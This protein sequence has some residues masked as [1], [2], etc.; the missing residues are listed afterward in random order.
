MPF[1]PCRGGG[2][3][4]PPYFCVQKKSNESTVSFRSED[5]KK[6]ETYELGGSGSTGTITCRIVGYNPTSSSSKELLRKSVQAN[7]VSKDNPW[8]IEAPESAKDWPYTQFNFSADT[9]YLTAHYK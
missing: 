5:I 8:V 2:N 7:S 4:K 9:V 1:Y 3:L 6:I